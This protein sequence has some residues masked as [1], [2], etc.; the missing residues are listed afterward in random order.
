MVY[1]K[2][3]PRVG[4]IT[5]HRWVREVNC[6]TDVLLDSIEAASCNEDFSK[7]IFHSHFDTGPLTKALLFYSQFLPTFLCY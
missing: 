5:V 4:H 2:Y 7:H 6:E 3:G 1:C